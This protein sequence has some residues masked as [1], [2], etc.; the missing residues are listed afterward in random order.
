MMNPREEKELRDVFNVFDGNRDG[1]I[2]T[3][4]LVSV[5]SSLGEKLS[6]ND[7]KEMIGQGDYDRDGKIDFYGKSMVFIM[8]CLQNLQ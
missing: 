4:D 1:F 2:S 5:M 3:A 7:A 8:S 6:E